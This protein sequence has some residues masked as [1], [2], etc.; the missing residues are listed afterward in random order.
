MTTGERRGERSRAAIGS[1][2]QKC[3]VVPADIDR[4]TAVPA[5]DLRVVRARWTLARE[6]CADDGDEE[7]ERFA[8][9][10][11]R[12]EDVAPAVGSQRHR[13]LLDGTKVEGDWNR[14]TP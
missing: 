10:R 9:S 2:R 12:Y 7:T 13:A 14:G 8:G 3:Q 11:T 6:D 4:A 1:T 5:G